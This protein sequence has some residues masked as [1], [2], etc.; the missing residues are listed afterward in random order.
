MYGL[1][2]QAMKELVIDA[3]GETTWR[4]IC[5]EAGVGD[6]D[7]RTMHAYPDAVTV[8]LVGAASRILDVPA[9]T[10]LEQFGTYWVGFAKTTDFAMLMRF[11]GS[12]FLEFVQNLD[13]M[14]AKI[15]LSLPE[16]TPP[17]FRCTEVT[18]SGFRLH[19]YSSR[20]GLAPLVVGMM[21]GVADLFG[22][23]IEMR[24]DRVAGAGQ[25]HDEFVI[26]YA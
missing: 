5:D 10:L 12:S 13:L 9:P 22:T 18:E 7:F 16:L 4:R 3:H 8:G 19:Y 15:K 2:N 25:D 20:Q 6:G 23:R 24:H 17:S 21:K 14:H 11:A 26:T 1:V